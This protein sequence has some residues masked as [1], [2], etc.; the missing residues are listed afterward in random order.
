MTDSMALAVGAAVHTAPDGYLPMRLALHC[1]TAGRASL[2]RVIGALA[3]QRLVEGYRVTPNQR[4][5]FREQDLIPT[6]EMYLATAHLTAAMP[7]ASN[8]TVCLFSTPLLEE[9]IGDATASPKRPRGQLAAFAESL[10]NGLERAERARAGAPG[11]API[12]Q[13]QIAY[14]S[15]VE[16]FF[17]A[18][19]ESGWGANVLDVLLAALLSVG[20]GED[21]TMELASV[22][23][24]FDAEFGWRLPHG[25][26]EPVA[27]L[28]GLST[29]LGPQ[30]RG[31]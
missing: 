30:E 16:R 17:P 6:E 9:I 1:S 7:A 10:A 27:W 20:R 26:S 18:D 8:E 14:A 12:V 5:P 31:D 23:N 19:P 24:A 15:F 28:F 21:P 22:L 3:E 4:L 29:F 13:R 2:A 25:P 11:L